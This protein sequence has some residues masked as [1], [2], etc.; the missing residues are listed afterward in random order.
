MQIAA[1]GKDALRGRR[2]VKV[3]GHADL[4]RWALAKSVRKGA[5]KFA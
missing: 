4:R 5:A 1:A 2:A 3:K